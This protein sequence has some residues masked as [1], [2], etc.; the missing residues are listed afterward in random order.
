VSVAGRLIDEARERALP[1]KEAAVVN[2]TVRALTVRALRK[3]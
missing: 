3:G 1:G 2:E